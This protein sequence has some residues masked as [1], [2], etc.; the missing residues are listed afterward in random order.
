MRSGENVPCAR[1]SRTC[2]KMPAHFAFSSSVSVTT[3]ILVFILVC[4]DFNGRYRNT[5]VTNVAIKAKDER[6]RCAVRQIVKIFTRKFVIETTLATATVRIHHFPKG[7]KAHI[8]EPL[9][10]LMEGSNHRR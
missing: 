2:L 8:S 4:I 10:C 5:L 3:V 6:G 9:R 1:R 7:G